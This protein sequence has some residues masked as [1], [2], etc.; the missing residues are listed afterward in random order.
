MGTIMKKYS[1]LAT[2]A[3]ASLSLSVVAQAIGPGDKRQANLEAVSR[4]TDS[5]RK[6]GGDNV[7]VWPGV[8]A[9]LKT[10]T[11][12]VVGEAVGLSKGGV[13]EFVLVSEISD[14]DYEALGVALAKPSDIAHALEAIGMPRG[15]PVQTRAFNFWP[16]GERLVFTMRPFAG[17]PEQPIGA[18][19]SDQQRGGSMTNI[20]TY[21]GS[22]W[23]DDNTCEADEETPG[24]IISCYNAPS[25]LIDLPYAITQNA[26]YGRFLAHGTPL[27][28]ES[29]W[30]FILRPELP[31]A[32]PPR[33]VSIEVKVVPAANLQAPAA[34]LA[35]LAWQWSVVNHPK[36]AT[37]KS[38]SAPANEN[39]KNTTFDVIAKEIMALAAASREPHLSL[40]FDDALTVKAATE[41]AAVV[42]AIEGDNGARLEGPPPNQLFLKAF[43]P[44]QEWRDREKRLLQ[45]YELRLER[46]EA[47]NWKRTFVYIHEDWSDPDSLDPKLTVQPMEIKDWSDMSAKVTEIGAG[48]GTLLVFVP[49]DA[50]LSAFMDGV[51]QVQKILPTIYI[52]PE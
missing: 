3:L 12:T 49:A 15:R 38:Q 43:M 29:L 52:L 4:W 37:D 41:A 7:C 23:Q 21:V 36:S 35:D 42:L 47:G 45:P 33:V 40:Y 44:Q 27:Q 30:Q 16:K 9:D 48:I 8:V 32:A 19:V 31:A 14:K 26:A 13:V 20:F 18:F 5:Q 46:D 51:R 24:S 2:A 28:K 22:V 34:G 25:T 10:R 17:G 50:P 39:H 6:N 1:W 11:V